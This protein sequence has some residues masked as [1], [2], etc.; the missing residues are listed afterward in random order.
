[1][2]TK[3]FAAAVILLNIVKIFNASNDSQRRWHIFSTFGFVFMCPILFLVDLKIKIAFA[4]LGVLT[5]FFGKYLERKTT[6]KQMTEIG[7]LIGSGFIVGICVAFGFSLFWQ[8]IAA[9]LG[10][11]VLFINVGVVGFYEET[12][13]ECSTNLIFDS[14]DDFLANFFH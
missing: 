3:V 8:V 11:V 9:T 4:I 10:Y 14:L 6:K 1:M 2:G 12:I 5:L 13:E 7:L